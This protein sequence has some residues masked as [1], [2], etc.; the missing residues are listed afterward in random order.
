M[1]KWNILLISFLS[2]LLVII[3]TIAGT[4]A[5]VINVSSEEGIDK[6]VNEITIKDLLT[7]DD[8]M[9]NNTYYTV[10]NELNVNEEDMNILMSSKELNSN[11]QVVLSSVVNYKLH[12]KNKLSNN[13]IYDL[14]VMSI[15]ED[16]NINTNL[17]NKV[18]NK[19]NYYKQDISDFIYDLEVLRIEYCMY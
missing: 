11:L 3:C 2:I 14:I 7:N 16:N 5:V 1:K 18:I 12:N 4:Y 6:I 9:Y 19:S 13:E 10:K 15:N 17:K 8:G